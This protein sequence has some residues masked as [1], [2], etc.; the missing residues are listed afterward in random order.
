M[1]KTFSEFW[2]GAFSLAAAYNGK[3]YIFY[4]L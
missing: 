3:N 1:S 4:S 2:L